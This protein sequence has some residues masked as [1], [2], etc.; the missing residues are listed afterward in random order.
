MWRFEKGTA[1]TVTPISYPDD[2][3]PARITAIN[4][5]VEKSGMIHLEATLTPHQRLMPSMSA[6][7]TLE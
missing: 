5:V 3:Y 4:P 6:I 7:I 1:I 2:R